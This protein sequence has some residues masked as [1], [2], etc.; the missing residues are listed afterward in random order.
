[1]PIQQSTTGA[2]SGNLTRNETAYMQGVLET[3][4][5]DQLAQP[6]GKTFEPRG[7]TTARF[8]LTDAL[9]RPTGAVGSETTD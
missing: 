6:V 8:W 1:M 9:P 2:T 4:T 3:R 5:Y 7:L